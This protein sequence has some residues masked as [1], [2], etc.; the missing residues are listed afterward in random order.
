MCVCG[1]VFLYIFLMCIYIHVYTYTYIHLYTYVNTYHI[2]VHFI[3]GRSGPGA[4][5]GAA[6][7]DQIKEI[8]K[9]LPYITIIA[10]GNVKTYEDCL[11]NLEE[12]D[13]DGKIRVFIVY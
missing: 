1:Y 4:R 3:V 6:H 2:Y 8:K 12:T 5:D 11:E 10:N 9:T 7:L 13:A